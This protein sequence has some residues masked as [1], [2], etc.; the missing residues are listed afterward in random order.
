MI[1]G[2]L[3]EDCPISGVKTMGR[4][5]ANTRRIGFI[6]ASRRKAVRQEAGGILQAHTHAE[7]LQGFRPDRPM[8]SHIERF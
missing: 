4:S 7:K 5:R 3:G 2:L 8:F 6:G 1:G